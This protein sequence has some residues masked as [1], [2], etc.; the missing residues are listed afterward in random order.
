MLLLL[1]QWRKPTETTAVQHLQSLAFQTASYSRRKWNPAGNKN[2]VTSMMKT[3]E[4]QPGK[5]CVMS[6]SLNALKCSVQHFLCVCAIPMAMVG[7]NTHSSFVN[8]A[9][10]KMHKIVACTAAPSN[11]WSFLTVQIFKNHLIQ[12][13]VLLLKQ[14]NILYQW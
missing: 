4:A 14:K 5:L 6:R 3:N 9:H 10:D 8:T 1:S 7:C 2:L 12:K 13:L 11:R